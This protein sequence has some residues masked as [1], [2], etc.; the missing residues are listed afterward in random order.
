MRVPR[1][2]GENTEDGQTSVKILDFP[3]PQC[4]W[5]EGNIGGKAGSPPDTLLRKR[6]DD[7]QEMKSS[8]GFLACSSSQPSAMGHEHVVCCI[9]V[10]MTMCMDPWDAGHG[11][12]KYVHGP[13]EPL[14]SSGVLLYLFDTVIFV[15]ITCAS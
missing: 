4:E 7:D 1:F 10:V 2:G 13:Y 8:Q 15:H 11:P 6:S 5:N 3:Q 14:S 12:W 9:Y